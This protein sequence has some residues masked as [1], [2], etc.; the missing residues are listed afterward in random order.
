[1]RRAAA[2]L[3]GHGG[4]STRIPEFTDIG[5]QVFLI[6][7]NESGAITGN[8]SRKRWSLDWRSRTAEG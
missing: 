5:L 6:T 3:I 2:V 8:R 4:A 7:A 1:M